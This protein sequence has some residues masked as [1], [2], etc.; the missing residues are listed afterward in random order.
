MH[1]KAVHERVKD[2]SSG[3]FDN[4][5]GGKDKINNH[6]K[7]CQKKNLPKEEI[8]CQLCE[9]VAEEETKLTDHLM[10]THVLYKE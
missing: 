9:Y 4:S 7:A 2:N 8:R 6:N 5:S 3:Q 10:S 1:L